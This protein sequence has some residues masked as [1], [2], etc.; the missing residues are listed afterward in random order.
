MRDNL[1]KVLI[2]CAAIMIITLCCC[3]VCFT[4]SMAY[5][6]SRDFKQALSTTPVRPFETEI[7]TE[8]IQPTV[9]PSLSPLDALRESILASLGDGNRNIPP[10]NKPDD[11]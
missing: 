6:L 10:P 2:A 5:L 9:A 11:G 1:T 7:P 4:T 8:A 3:C